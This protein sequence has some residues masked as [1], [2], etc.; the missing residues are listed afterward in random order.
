MEK[1]NNRWDQ[2]LSEIVPYMQ[3]FENDKGIVDYWHVRQHNHSTQEIHLILDGECL[4][5]V[6]NEEVPLKKGQGILIAPHLYHGPQW[7]TKPFR[8]LN[9][10]FSLSEAFLAELWKEEQPPFF[11]FEMNEQLFP[12]YELILLEYQQ[13]ES[14]FHKVAITDLYSTMLIH[15]LRIIQKSVSIEKREPKTKTQDDASII[16]KFFGDTPL[17]QQTKKNLAN[18]LHCSERQLLRKIYTYYGISFREKQNLSRI[19]WAK[20]LLQNTDK[21]IWEI[22]ETIGYSNAAFHKMFRQHTGTTPAKYR[23]NVQSPDVTP[24]EKTHQ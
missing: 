23:K 10:V 5:S 7:T 12:L 1:L 21:E 4:L 13:S 19:E 17:Q 3:W 18:L 16:D 15:V 2:S 20:H 11:V 8:R 22:S 9:I 14:P 6:G 24:A